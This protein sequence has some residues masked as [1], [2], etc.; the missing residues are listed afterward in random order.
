VEFGFLLLVAVGAL[1]GF[2]L[3]RRV[4]PIVTRA[5]MTAGVLGVV[6]GLTILGLTVARLSP[7]GSLTGGLIAVVLLGLAGIVLS[8]AV[9]VRWS[10]F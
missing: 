10:R 6:L 8:F 2:A 7:F 9:V 3:R 5:L 1:L 4:S